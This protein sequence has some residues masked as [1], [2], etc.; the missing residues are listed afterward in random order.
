MITVSHLT[1]PWPTLRPRLIRTDHSPKVHQT[2]FD[3]RSPLLLL[4]LHLLQRFPPSFSKEPETA[5]ARGNCQT[6][7]IFYVWDE[8]KMT[9]TKVFTYTSIQRL[10][11]VDVTFVGSVSLQSW[12][13]ALCT[14][15]WTKTIIINIWQVEHILFFW[16]LFYF[17]HW[18]P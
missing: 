12:S 2:T 17:T 1:P 5:T 4:S 6:C 10:R 13:H 18:A 8:Q 11:T 9:T 3:N 15:V 16:I 14:E 7:M